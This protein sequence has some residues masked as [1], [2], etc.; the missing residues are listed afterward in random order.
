MHIMIDLNIAYI[1]YNITIYLKSHELRKRVHSSS[2]MKNTF[3]W[4]LD[5]AIPSFLVDSCQHL[6][7][8]QGTWL[9]CSLPCSFLELTI[10]FP[11]RGGR[12]IDT[13]NRQRELP[14]QQMPGAWSGNKRCLYPLQGWLCW[15]VLGDIHILS[16]WWGVI[17]FW[18]QGFVFLVGW[19]NW[20]VY[21]RVS[22]VV[23]FI[24]FL[25]IWQIEA[26]DPFKIV[27]DF[28]L[29][30]Q[31]GIWKRLVRIWTTFLRGQHQRSPTLCKVH[32][33][34]FELH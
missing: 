20:F 4:C 23:L 27:W 33:S 9:W 13:W 28:S 14:Q 25:A 18:L 31:C 5:M 15:L 17:H 3:V 29:L 26:N 7:S 19:R 1:W 21:S 10:H 6:G 30:T 12:K 16:S 24:F 32:A 11:G 34:C 22:L 8:T 2:D